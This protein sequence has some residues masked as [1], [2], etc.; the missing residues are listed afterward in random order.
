MTPAKPRS[1]K[2]HYGNERVPGY[3]TWLS[4]IARCEN[5]RT[6]SYPRYGG[7]GIT[8]CERWRGSFADFIA[9]VGPRPSPSHSIDRINVNGNYE[10]GNCRWA[11]AVEQQR[12]RRSNR[13]LTI[14]GRT[15][16][17]QAWADEVG[18]KSVTLQRRISKGMPPELAVLKPVRPG[19]GPKVGET[20][21]RGVTK[22]RG[23]YRAT[24]NVNGT[25]INLGTFT[26][27]EVAARAY[28]DAVRRFGLP[29]SAPNFPEGESSAI[30]KVA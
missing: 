3:R 29:Q 17:L 30:G 12:N 28:E 4:M 7:R 6:E 27:P 20:G 5:P 18:I 21:Y 26:A 11:T 8:V 13:V 15:Q 2:V 19:H 16:C 10:P 1:R 25:K 24:I 22:C 14:N 23:R 9:D